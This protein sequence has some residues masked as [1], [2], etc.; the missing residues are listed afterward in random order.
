[1]FKKYKLNPKSTPMSVCDG[2]ISFWGV[3][4]D[5]IAKQFRFLA[6]NGMG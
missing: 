1:M 6:F 3:L 2:G 5:I 4:F